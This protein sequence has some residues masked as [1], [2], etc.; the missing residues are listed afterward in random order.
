MSGNPCPK[1]QKPKR[2]KPKRIVNPE[3][4]E[5]VR[6]L[7]C[8]ACW[9]DGYGGVPAQIHHPRSGQGMGQRAG[10]DKSIPLCEK[11]HQGLVYLSNEKALGTVS[12]HLFPKEFK[13]KYGTEDDLLAIV[14][15]LLEKA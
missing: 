1:G 5:R 14:A 6:V 8:V 4:R 15:K 2:I 12:I 3:Y 7:G 9:I 10:D 11:H 13:A